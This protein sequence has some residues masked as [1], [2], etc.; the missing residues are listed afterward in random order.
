MAVRFVLCASK[1]HA[2]ACREAG[3]LYLRYGDD[4]YLA[5]GLDAQWVRECYDSLRWPSTDFAIALED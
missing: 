1:E 2:I 5:M 3:L 4:W